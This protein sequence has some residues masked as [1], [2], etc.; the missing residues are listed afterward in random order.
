[1]AGTVILQAKKPRPNTASAAGAKGHLI[2]STISRSER[3]A[4]SMLYII[5]GFFVASMTWA[6]FA[7]LDRVTR[8]T[9]RVV[10]SRQVQLVQN[11]EGGIIERILVREGQ[12]VEAGAPLF[13][14]DKTALKSQFDRGRQQQLAL[15]AKI[16]RLM[17]QINQSKLAFPSDV[18]KEAP[19][20]VSTETL[21]FAGREAEMKSQIRFLEGQ[22]KQ[23]KQE[24]QEAKVSLETAKQGHCGR[25]RRGHTSGRRD[26]AGVGRRL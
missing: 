18:V 23:R 2:G 14:L 15:R 1:M 16:V 22:I 9:G 26:G 6:S 20:V 3:K 4:N 17:A 25:Q 10:P 5:V 21:L 24:L 7:E 19:R 11:L 13:V 12:V 8:G